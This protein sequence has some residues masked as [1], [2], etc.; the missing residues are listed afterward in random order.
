VEP[1]KVDLSTPLKEYREI[2]PVILQLMRIPQ[3]SP[4]W[5]KGHLTTKS[6]PMGIALCSA[7]AESKIITESLKKS[8]AIFG[9]I[10]PIEWLERSSRIPFQDNE[11]PS[12]CK[13]VRKLSRVLDPDEQVG[14]LPGSSADSKKKQDAAME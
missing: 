13:T 9:G 3:L 2:L 6:G 1:P 11:E 14:L 4:L 12:S 7:L 8:L 5:K 10:N